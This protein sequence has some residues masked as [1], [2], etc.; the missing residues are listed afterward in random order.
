M[1]LAL[2]SDLHGN[3]RALEACLAHAQARG[4]DHFAVLGDLVGYGADPS[5][6]VTRVQALHDAG[7]VVLKGNHDAMAVAPPEQVRTHGEQTARWTHTRLDATQREWL[8]AL[9][10]VATLDT[11]YLV[12]ASANGPELWHYV[13]DAPHAVASL[14]AARANAPHIQF[15]FNGHVHEQSLYYQGVDGN[16]LQFLPQPGVAIPVPPARQWLATVGSVGQPRD[17]RPDA[18][19]AILDTDRWTLTFHRVAY[20][21]HGAARDIRL[22]GLPEYLAARLERGR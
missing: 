2:L 4:S 10:L 7:A 8:Q 19:Y 9:P 21:F 6:V 17:G 11:L 1:Q 22:A 3:I 14:A 12:H 15:V 13:Y 16:L 20:N 18:M 5:A